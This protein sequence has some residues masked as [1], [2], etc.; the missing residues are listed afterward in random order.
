[1]TEA[2]VAAWIAAQVRARL[3]PDA[4]MGRLE[5]AVE[6][7]TRECR[8]Q[9]LETLVQ[10]AAGRPSLA[11]PACARALHVEAYGRARTVQAGCGPVSFR[12]DYGFC[13]DCG[14]HAYPADHALG[15]QPRAPASPRVQELCAVHALRG[16]TAQYAEDFRRLTGLDL[17]PSTVHR[18]A[19][20]QGVRAQASRDADAALVHTAAGIARLAA[21]A[22]ALAVDDTLV[23]EIDA[24]NIRERDAWG[25]TE[26][27]RRRGQQPE[28][29]HWVYTATIFRLDQRGTTQAGRPIIAERGFVATRLGLEAFRDQLYAEALRRGVSQAKQVLV[30]ADGAIWIWNLIDDRFAGAQQRVDLYHVKGHLWAVAHDLFGQGTP[31]AAAWVAPHLKALENRRDGALDVLHGLEGLRDTLTNLST[32]QRAAL[33]REIGYFNQHQHRM[34][35]K[36]GKRR[37]QPIGSGAIES[38]CSQYQRRFK[39]TGQFWSLAGDEALLALATL[40]RNSRWHEL[41]PHDRVRSG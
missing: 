21:Q 33:E 13:P 15:L 31:E 3:P 29:W 37:G 4:D 14:Q 40:H 32:P 36:A 41:F 2:S 19:R 35:Y 22:P 26:R 6:N 17:D 8:R 1:M 24:W 23:L 10:E 5:L 7:A 18:E 25:L 39:L 38:T 20:R 12:R 16:P 28:R 27:L 30:L 9:A 34:D 11:C